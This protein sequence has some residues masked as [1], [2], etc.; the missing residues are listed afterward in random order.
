M[1]A[2]ILARAANRPRGGNKCQACELLTPEMEKAIQEARAAGAS[3]PAIHETLE[4]DPP[5]NMGKGKV[6]FSSLYA[7]IAARHGER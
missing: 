6:S 2:A 7:H 5:F 4:L 3:F 1:A